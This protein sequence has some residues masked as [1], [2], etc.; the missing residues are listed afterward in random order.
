MN[1]TDRH[2]AKPRS[3]MTDSSLERV[4]EDLASYA[5]TQH[6]AEAD[7]LLTEVLASLFAPK[8]PP[9]DEERI[10]SESR[11]IRAIWDLWPRTGPE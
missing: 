11:A 3:P 10:A 7:E 9:S 5:R 6:L 2:F 8:T 4:I 1:A